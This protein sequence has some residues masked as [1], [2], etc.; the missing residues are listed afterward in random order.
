[1]EVLSV[2]RNLVG[3][4]SLSGNLK[5]SSICK[6]QSSSSFLGFTGGFSLPLPLKRQEGRSAIRAPSALLNAHEYRK[7][8]LEKVYL[9][10]MGSDNE[11]DNDEDLCPIECVREIS[12]LSELEHVIEGSKS[13]G[14]LVV[15]DFFRTSC[16]SCRYIERGFQKLCKGAGDGE[17][18]VV[19]LKHNVMDE[20]DEQSDI[21]EKFKI[22]VVPLFHFYKKGEL[23]EQFPTRDKA[24]ILQAIYKHLDVDQTIEE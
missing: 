11:S 1:M 23:V 22:K 5:N 17:A 14:A 16:G 13:N 21:A 20:Y 24:R 18:S 6:A 10:E 12:K 7:Q 9:K 8:K 3:S 19:F 15:V 2:S 4:V